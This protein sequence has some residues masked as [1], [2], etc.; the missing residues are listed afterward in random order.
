MH[1]FFPAPY[2][3]KREFINTIIHHFSTLVFSDSL[4]RLKNVK[5]GE[6]L[7]RYPLQQQQQQQQQSHYRHDD[8]H[9]DSLS[10]VGVTTISNNGNNNTTS[11]NSLWKFNDCSN[12][13]ANGSYPYVFAGS[14]KYLCSGQYGTTG[15]TFLNKSSNSCQQPQLQLNSIDRYNGSQSRASINLVQYKQQKSKSRDMEENWKWSI[16][17]TS[18]KSH[19]VTNGVFE[20]DKAIYLLRCLVHGDEIVLSQQSMYLRTAADLATK[21]Y[22]SSIS[23]SLTYNSPIPQGI[24][25]K[26]PLSVSSFGAGDRYK[27]SSSSDSSSNGTQP[28]SGTNS[29]YTPTLKV[30][31]YNI[32]SNKNKPFYVNNPKQSSPP[33]PQNATSTPPLVYIENKVI[34]S[35]QTINNL[36]AAYRW[37]IEMVSKSMISEKKKKQEG[38]T[39]TKNLVIKSNDKTV[40]EEQNNEIINNSISSN[41]IKPYIPKLS[42]DITRCSTP[43]TTTNAVSDDG[44]TQNHQVS[45]SLSTTTTANKNNNIIGVSSMIPDEDYYENLNQVLIQQQQYPKSHQQQQHHLKLKSKSKWL[46]VNTKFYNLGARAKEDHGDDNNDVDNQQQSSIRTSQYETPMEGSIKSITSPAASFVPAATTSDEMMISE[47]KFGK[48]PLQQGNAMPVP[49]VL[50][51]MAAK[52]DINKNLKD[53]GDGSDSCSWSSLSQSSS[54]TTSPINKSISIKKST[55]AT[56]LTEAETFKRGIQKTYQEQANAHKMIFKNLFSSSSS[57]AS[58]KS[59]TTS[60]IR[61]YDDDEEEEEEDD[62]ATEILDPASSQ[63]RTYTMTPRSH[64]FF[65]QPTTPSSSAF[66]T[67]EEYMKRKRSRENSFMLLLNQETKQQMWLRAIKQSTLSHWLRVLSKGTKKLHQKS[68]ILCSP[69]PPTSSSS[70]QNNRSYISSNHHFLNTSSDIRLQ[71]HHNSHSNRVIQKKKGFYFKKKSKSNSS[72]RQRS[73][74]L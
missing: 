28:T 24:Y 27:F 15:L 61:Y 71:H 52:F 51:P 18:P 46:D 13:T 43:D 48:Q 65:S 74:V 5:S 62:Q 20:L 23:S 66:L 36:S 4:I 39:I 53:S 59:S 30:Q 7:G 40:K 68:M 8:H 31:Q 16:D 70:K 21:D 34:S 50:L 2:D 32:I 3:E 58:P 11:S 38:D 44:H 73:I 26:S 49:K 12:S 56:S 55:P 64:R 35:T 14:E 60:Q 41:S 9:L 72:R 37:K 67:P 10:N 29:F 63:L 42:L 33:P 54:A 47:K 22:V 25:A 45:S 57:C 19:Y 17:F 6:Y 69:P 1:E